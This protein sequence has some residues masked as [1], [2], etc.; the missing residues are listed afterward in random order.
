MFFG[1]VGYSYLYAGENLARD[2]YDSYSL[3]DS[4]MSSDTHRKNLLS[5]NF[6]EVGFGIKEGYLNGIKTYIVVQMLG[7]PMSNAQNNAVTLTEEIVRNHLNHI[8][9]IKASW[10]VNNDRYS[11]E[12]INMLLDSF[13]RQISFCNTILANFETGKGNTSESISLWNGVIK[14]SNETGEITKRLNNEI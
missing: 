9:S 14:M 5:P 2:F 8:I 12:D 11:R 10:E 1:K 4:W 13:N 7:T 3:I 6:T